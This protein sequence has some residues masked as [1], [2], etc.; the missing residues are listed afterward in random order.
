MSTTPIFVIHIFCGTVGLFSGGAAM[1]YR[2]GSPR[3][4][5]VGK[6]FGISMICLAVTGIFLAILKS[7]AGNIF[8]GALTAYLVTT[9]WRVARRQ[10][11]ATGVF[12]WVAMLAALAITLTASAL[13]WMAAVSPSGRRFGH[14][15]YVYFVLGSIA[16]VC[17][18]GDIR[19]LLRGG[20]QGTQRLTRHLWRMCSAWFIAAASIFATRP[21]LFP[22]VMRKSGALIFLTALP[23]LLMVFWMM[24]V[25]FTSAYKA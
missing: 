6:L 4:L 8:G 21:Q 2:K 12:D 15:A 5:A 1:L 20:V 25:R 18:A 17:T 16:L 10:D 19:M 9:A 3:H 22:M 13:A 7:Q 14:P 23:G 11:T 24:R